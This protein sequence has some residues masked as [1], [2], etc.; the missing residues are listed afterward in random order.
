[1]LQTLKIKNFALIADQTIEFTNGFNVLVGET[2]AGKSL[3]LDAISFVMG[4]KANKLNIRHNEQKMSVWAIFD[5]SST[6]LD[7]LNENDIEPEDNLIVSRSLT[8]EGKSD[9]RIN[10]SIVT[11]S[12][13]KMLASLMLDTYAQN[14]NIELL[15]V[16]NHLAILDKYAG[17][18]LNCYKQEISN[19][20]QSIKEIQQKID[21]F[22]GDD[23]SRQ[24]K[25]ELLDYQI[26]DIENS[27]LQIGEDEE[28]KSEI[29]KLSNFEKIYESIALANSCL[30][31]VNE[32]LY[33]A[34]RALG[35]VEKYDDGLLEVFNRLKSARI[36]IKDIVDSLANY[37]DIGF[38]QNALDALNKR[39]DEIKLLKK[40]YGETIQDINN[41]LIKIKEEYDDL[42]FGEE[43]LNKL[44]KQK[45]E[46]INLLHSVC[47][48]LSL[49]R[50]EYALKIEE[51]VLKELSLLGFKNCK[52]KVD[53]NSLPSVGDAKFNK[54]G[55]DEVEFLFSANAGEDLKSLSKTISGGEMSR[56]MLALK[57]VFANCFDASTLIFD[58]VDTGISGEIG[59]KVAERLAILSKSFQLICIT[60]LCQVTAMADNYI[61]VKKEVENNNT[62]TKVQYLQGQDILKYIAGVSGAEPTDVALKFATELKQKAN[63]FKNNI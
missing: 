39:Y 57:N 34:E 46:Q 8:I 26:K 32:R 10:G 6:V 42:L 33:D 58:E 48:S 51:L 22:G 4:D 20:L 21:L 29:N 55:I 18:E 63:N 53:F 52:F 47:T 60:H 61:F 38:D 36:E 13:L 56:F 49:K 54:T 2:G 31:S 59:Q 40:K 23:A 24:R 9:C 45:D 15:K 19:Y 1:M 25:V 5:N 28:V 12:Q 27:N 43:K 37:S 44:L 30:E 16:K 62:F 35:G 41:Y 17:E 50:K 7:F 11:V 3:I 14:E